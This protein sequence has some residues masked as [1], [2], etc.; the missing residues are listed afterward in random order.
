MSEPAACPLCAHPGL[1]PIATVG[2]TEFRACTQCA[3]HMRD[4]QA[5]P[6]RQAE[7]AH[8]ALHDNQPDDAGYRRFLQPLFDALVARLPSAAHG[9]DFGCGN[10]S[11]LAAMLREA[12]H[13]VAL[14]DPLFQPDATALAQRYAFVTASEVLEHLHRPLDTLTVLD[15][16]L[17]ADGW[18]GVMTG[19]PP[20]TVEAFQRWHYLRDPTHVLFYP[21]ETMEWIG[22]HF[23]WR[24]EMPA[25]NVTL[26]RKAAP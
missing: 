24:V 9:L 19:T 6:E 26:F 20:T 5:W 22:A 18:L 10:G 13:R 16:L 2:G 4:P 25:P 11:A 3:L 7:R 8:Y 14:Y 21:P 17:E 12:G 23:G 15:S 1:R